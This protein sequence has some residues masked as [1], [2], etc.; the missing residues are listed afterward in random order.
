MLRQA[1]LERRQVHETNAD[2]ISRL[3]DLGIEGLPL[4]QLT[5]SPTESDKQ[6][7]SA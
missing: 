3:L 5:F 7:L 2:R 1:A 4:R 6:K